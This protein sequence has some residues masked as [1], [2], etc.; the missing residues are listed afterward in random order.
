MKNKIQGLLSIS[1]HL[2]A[3]TTLTTLHCVP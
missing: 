2:S 1:G 3:A